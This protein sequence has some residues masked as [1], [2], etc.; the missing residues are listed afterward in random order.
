MKWVSRKISADKKDNSFTVSFGQESRSEIE[1]TLIVIRAGGRIHQHDLVR[2]S[3]GVNGGKVRAARPE[4]LEEL[5]KALV[6]LG[7]ELK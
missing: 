7:W 4:S 2:E 3:D 5:Q 1:D 6:K